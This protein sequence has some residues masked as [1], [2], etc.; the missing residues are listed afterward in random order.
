MF[1]C[2]CT[3]KG[4]KQP[5]HHRNDAIPY[6]Q[7]HPPTT[8]TTIAAWRSS[9]RRQQLAPPTDQRDDVGLFRQDDA[10]DEVGDEL[11]EVDDDD[12]GRLVTALGRQVEAGCAEHHHATHGYDQVHD[13]VSAAASQCYVE[14]HVYVGFVATCVLLRGQRR[15]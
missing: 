14:R 7:R 15:T 10:E 11:R 6:T 2:I 8:Q 9:E 4:S 1:I 5:V 13:V 3:L 12:D